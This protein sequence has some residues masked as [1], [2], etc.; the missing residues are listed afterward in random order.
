M[1]TKTRTNQPFPTST[2]LRKSSLSAKDV[3]ALSQ[4]KARPSLGDAEREQMFPEESELP[5]LDNETVHR[6]ARPEGAILEDDEL[7]DELAQEHQE[8]RDEDVR[9]SNP[10]H[11]G[12]FVGR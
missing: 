5:D 6:T 10:L 9:E 12:H 7:D 4:S 8:E 3:Q 11:V 1:K 2:R